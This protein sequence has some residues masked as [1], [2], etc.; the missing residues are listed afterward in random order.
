MKS[1]Q[2]LMTLPTFEERFHYL[3]TG[4]RVGEATFGYERWLNQKFYSS[5]E[6]RKVRR[7]IAIRDDGCDLGC[8]DYPISGRIHVHHINPITAEDIQNN[9][10]KLFDPNNL[11]ST[12]EL[13]HKALTYGSYDDLPKPYIPRSMHDTS[14]WRTE[15]S[16]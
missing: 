8:E 1:Y 11:I 15:T 16:K 14:P 12:S 3:E 10:P 13:T 9:D 6:W 7:Q 2:D 5:N 4:N